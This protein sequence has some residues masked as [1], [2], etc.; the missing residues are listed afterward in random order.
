M[1]FKGWGF[2]KPK[3]SPWR[4]GVFIACNSFGFPR[5]D[6]RVDG[7]GSVHVLS[8]LRCL[9]KPVALPGGLAYGRNTWK[10]K[11]QTCRLGWCSWNL[12]FG[13]AE[14][15]KEKNS[16]FG[17]C[18]LWCC[19]FWQCLLVTPKC[20]SKYLLNRW[21]QWFSQTERPLRF[22]IVTFYFESVWC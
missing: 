18:Q 16:H 8:T 7:G 19:Q 21:P 3:V 17:R 14:N 15:Q 4:G 6:F 9:V 5:K 2:M 22:R 11:P 1:L 13:K 12:S 20:L 10:I